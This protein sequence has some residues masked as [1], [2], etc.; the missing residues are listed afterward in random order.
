MTKSID[1]TA[2]KKRLPTEQTEEQV[3]K[4]SELFKEFDPNGNG[5]L[6]LAEVDKGCRDVLGLYEIFECK[7]VIMRAFQAAKS[8]H[9]AKSGG[10]DD[11]GPDF[12]QRIE[13]R[14]LLV[15]LGKYFEIWQMFEEIDNSDDHRITIDEFKKAL[16][17]IEAWGVKVDDP[18][19]AFAEIDANGGGMVL[20]VE[21]TEWAI[22]KK[23][24]IEDDTE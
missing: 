2:I 9:N 4:R 3:A 21:F 10:S 18:D 22:A 16:P 8:A 15:Y 17:Q 5:F 11:L 23:L 7:K 6:S 12:V 13:F 1:W 20:F 14:L 24:E 19:A